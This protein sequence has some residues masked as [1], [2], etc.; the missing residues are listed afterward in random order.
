MKSSKDTVKTLFR[1]GGGKMSVCPM[2]VTYK[3]YFSL[4]G[5]QIFLW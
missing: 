1:G 5:T 3:G 2:K 4:S